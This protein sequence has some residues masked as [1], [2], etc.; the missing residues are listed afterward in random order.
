MLASLK[1]LRRLVAPGQLALDLHGPPSRIEQPSPRM[2][3][4]PEARLAM[5]RP[6]PPPRLPATPPR[7]AASASAAAALLARLRALGLR[8]I[9]RAT[10]TRNRTTMVSF[11]GD[12]LRLHHA[13]VTAP[14][15]ILRAVVDF[16]NGRGARRREAR[17][18]LA[19]FEI[20]YAAEDRVRRRPTAHPDDAALVARLRDAH[21]AL[22]AERFDGALQ[23]VAIR[24]SRRMRSRLGHY[25]PGLRSEPEIAIARR[26][27]RRDGF[28]SVLE[29]LVHEMVHQWQHETGRPV[30]HD[31]AF[32]RKCRDVGIAPHAKRPY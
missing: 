18:V 12:A 31:P 4:A 20:P 14:E 9:T 8:G 22:N 26:H 21:A 13:F 30:A 17:R 3:P 27:V 25:S 2:E 6:E 29:T 1:R 24:V 7:T 16:V 23:P 10:L 15:A 5:P 11:R 32:R 19:G 28:G